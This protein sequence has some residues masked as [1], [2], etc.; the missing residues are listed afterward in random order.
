MSALWSAPGTFITVTN[1]FDMGRYFL[2]IAFIAPSMVLA[3]QSPNPSLPTF[4][5]AIIRQSNPDVTAP[6]QGF[7]VDKFKTTNQTIKEL[8]VFAYTLDSGSERKMVGAPKWA[9]TTQFDIEAKQ[10]DDFTAKLKGMSRSE[11][12]GQIR[13]EV[14]ALLE[15]RFKL[16]V[17]HET[18]I[19]SVYFLVPLKTGT[20]LTLSSDDP[21]PA[22][23]RRGIVSNLPKGQILAREVPP[24]VLAHVLELTTELGGSTVVDKTGLS[25]KYN[26]K[27]EWTPESISQTTATDLPG[28]SLFAALQSQL[29]L[30]LESGKAPVDMVVIDHVEMPSE[31]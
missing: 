13:L 15:E 7:A 9:D 3:Q 1:R 27:L 5:V 28:P 26:F 14:R 30:K 18:R 23:S 10:E 17:H 12:I 4:E 31:N 20:K 11:Q 6:L 29:G 22:Q 16:K 25:G 19:Q 2:F 24:S 8:I 21:S